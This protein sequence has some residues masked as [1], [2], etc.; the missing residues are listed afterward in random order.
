MRILHLP[1]NVADDAWSLMMGQRELGLDAQL[2]C[3]L[4]N[5]FAH[6]GSI[7]L[8]F[9]SDNPFM[10]QYRKWRF[11]QDELPRFNVTH[12]HAGSSIFDYSYGGGLLWLI[13]FKQAVK[14]EQ[15]VAMTYH[16]CEVRDLQAGGCP[17]LCDNP[18]CREGFDKR[19][20]IEMINRMAHLLYVTTP[21]LLA[22]VPE[23]QL[24]PQSVY[25]LRDVKPS[26][27]A[28]E[29]VLR[30]AHAPTNRGRKGTDYIIEA[31]ENLCTQGMDIELDLIEKVSHDESLKRMRACDVFIDQLN[32]GWYGVASVEAASMGKPIITRIDEDLIEVSRMEA[33]PFVRATPESIQRQIACLYEN[34]GM[35][36]EFGEKCRRFV[37]S[38]HDATNNA[39]RV[40]ADYTATR[41]M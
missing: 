12:F 27:P 20:R 17:Y 24:L 25:G 7:D 22:A 14:R 37:I 19:P 21:D 38:R 39:A 3:I 28:P 1:Q 29:G 36:P 9:R 26:Y 15:V 33:P 32:I 30:L 2:A 4:D 41:D 10:R 6:D 31:V 35:L 16:G 23:A 34:R 11:I 5:P 18:V 40:V 13:D 8:T